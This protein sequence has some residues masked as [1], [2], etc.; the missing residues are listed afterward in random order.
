[1]ASQEYTWMHY[2]YVVNATATDHAYVN[3]GNS[4]LMN[5]IAKTNSPW[6]KVQNWTRDDV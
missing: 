1:L 6:S 2:S 4:E 3:Y 5:Y